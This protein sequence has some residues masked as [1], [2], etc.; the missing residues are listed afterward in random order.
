MCWLCEQI[1]GTFLLNVQ[2]GHTKCKVHYSRGHEIN[3]TSKSFFAHHSLLLNLSDICSGMVQKS[4]IFNIWFTRPCPSTRTP[5]PQ[6]IKFTI[7]VD[8]SLV[9]YYI[10]SLSDLCQGVE[11]IWEEIHQLYDFDF[12]STPLGGRHEIYNFLSPYPADAT[13]QIW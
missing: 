8:P 5:A 2:Y 11:K 10:L 7:L 4:C 9:Q 6:V 1:N 13:S 12:K 3:S